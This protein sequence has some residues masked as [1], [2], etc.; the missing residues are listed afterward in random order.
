MERHSLRLQAA[1]DE[2]V[3]TLWKMFVKWPIFESRDFQFRL[4]PEETLIGSQLAMEGAVG[5]Q[6]LSRCGA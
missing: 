5:V 1:P 6:C 3:G 4:P 2:P